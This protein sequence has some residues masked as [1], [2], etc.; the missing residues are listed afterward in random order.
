MQVP[1]RCNKCIENMRSN[2]DNLTATVKPIAI[3]GNYENQQYA[4]EMKIKNVVLLLLNFI[5]I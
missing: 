3:Y 1:I 4:G 5:K 2:D